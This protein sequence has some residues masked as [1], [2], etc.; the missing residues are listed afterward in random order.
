MTERAMWQKTYDLNVIGTQIMTSTFVPLLLKSK[1]PRLLFVTSGTATLS[2][3]EDR[4]I[5]VNRIPSK[6]WPKAEFSLPSYRTSKCALNMMMREWHRILKE[7]GVKVWCLSPG[8]LATN[9]GN[10][11]EMLKK[12]GAGDPAVAG[13]FI[14]DILEGRRDDDTGLVVIRDGVQPW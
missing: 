8:L 14:K 9:L 6:G 2:G 4:S 12:I 7:D 1:D 5:I 11:P 10:N 13:P 3:T